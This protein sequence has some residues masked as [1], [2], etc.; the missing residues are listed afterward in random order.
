MAN[1]HGNWDLYV[2]N[3]DGSNVRR[4]TTHP[5][6]DGLPVW[7]P[8][9]EWLAFLSNRGGVWGIWLLHVD[10]GDIRQV[11]ELSGATFTPP[12]GSPYGQRNWW[13][14]QLSWSK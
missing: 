10:S 4:L 2:V 13:D 3:I 5:A 1:P 6:V 11:V 7:S 9:G 8:D 12:A 14:E